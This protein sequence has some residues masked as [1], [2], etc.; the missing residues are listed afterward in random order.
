MR[1][2]VL[3]YTL[4]A[5]A[6]QKYDSSLGGMALRLQPGELLAAAMPSG[7]EVSAENS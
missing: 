4:G 1:A 6:L 5:T 3:V 2:P 7:I